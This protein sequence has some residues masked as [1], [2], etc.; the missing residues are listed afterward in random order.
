MPW[1]HGVAGSNPA[2]ETIF[3]RRVKME[4]E[5]L[6][7]KERM[8]SSSK[9]IECICP[10]CRTTHKVYMFW[11]GKSKPRKYCEKCKDLISKVYNLC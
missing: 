8:K 6:N 10:R 1:E 2:G 7:Y 9:S 11:T 3:Y 4:Y 5:S